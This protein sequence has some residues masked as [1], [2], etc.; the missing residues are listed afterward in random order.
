M[1]S[2]RDGQ[3]RRWTSFSH[4]ATSAP[5]AVVAVGANLVGLGLSAVAML[6]LLAVP[7]TV[8]GPDGVFSVHVQVQ[9]PAYMRQVMLV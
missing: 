7:E 3:R 9:I 8:R 6:A 5:A 2:H 1:L 4:G